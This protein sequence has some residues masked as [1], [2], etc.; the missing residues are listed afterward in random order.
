MKKILLFTIC[1]FVNIVSLFSEADVLINESENFLIKVLGEVKIENYIALLYYD[2]E[3][4]TNELTVLDNDNNR[5]DISKPGRTEEFRIVIVGNQ[6][7]SNSLEVKIQGQKFIGTLGTQTQDIDTNLYVNAI[8]PSLNDDFIP[9]F[10]IPYIISL[11]IE[12]GVH[13][14]EENIVDVVF[15]LAWKGNGNLPAGF[16][17]SDIDIEYSVI[18]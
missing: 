10:N 3:Q 18:D 16:Y 1:L 7:Q 5:F 13:S 2:N 8:S 14:L 12:E 4:L 9:N 15:V 17:S 11:D 6:T